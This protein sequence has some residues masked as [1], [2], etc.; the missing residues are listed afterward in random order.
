M[1][2][3]AAGVMGL[4]AT[5]ASARTGDESMSS[6]GSSGTNGS[7]SSRKAD[8]AVTLTGVVRDFRQRNTR[9]GHPDFGST[10]AEG[11]GVYA[12]IAHD[13]LDADGD[14]VFRCT[15]NKVLTPARDAQQRPMM[16][17]KNYVE[18]R[19]GDTAATL[20]TTEGGAV[21][22]ATSFS[23]WFKDNPLTNMSAPF[24]IPMQEVNGKLGYDGDLRTQ[25][26]SLSGFGGNKVFGYTFEVECQITKRAASEEGGVA[27]EQTLTFGAD[28][29][30]WVFINGKLVIDLGGNHEYAEQ[31]IDLSRLT[32]LTAG[33]PATMKIFYAERDKTNSRFKMETTASLT[34]AIQP[35]VTS[36]WD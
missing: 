28:D 32:W 1:L 24:S 36:Q 29:C 27:A 31:T 21:Q 14:P 34:R 11:R 25:F 12:N 13:Q 2:I 6:G 20:A 33:E 22:S 15:G 17:P 5:S 30:L 19:P 4:L 9:N 10:P 26:A 35:P 23:D 18:V 16:Q 7:G 3:C 8:S